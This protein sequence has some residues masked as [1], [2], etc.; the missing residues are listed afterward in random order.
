MTLFYLQTNKQKKF[1]F[2]LM[3]VKERTVDAR[4]RFHLYSVETVNS[5]PQKYLGVKYSV[6]IFSVYEST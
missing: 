6:I 5:I 1:R 2:E 3:K 4:Q